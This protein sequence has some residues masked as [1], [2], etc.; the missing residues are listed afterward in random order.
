MIVPVYNK[1]EYVA[2]TIES[3]C[4][5]S[6]RNLE[7]ILVND[8]STD[9]SEVVCMQKA[10]HDQRIKYITQENAGPS[11]AR[12]HGLNV[13]TG[14]YITFLDADDILIESAVESMMGC[15]QKYQADIV[16]TRQKIFSNGSIQTTGDSCLQSGIVEK[17]AFFKSLAAD[18][19]GVFWGSQGNKLYARKMISAYDLHF[20]IDRRHA[21]DFLFNLSCF[22]LFPRIAF[23]NEVTSEIYDVPA[24]LSK[25][26]NIESLTMWGGDVWKALTDFYKENGQERLL[27]YVDS[28]FCR[29]VRGAIT[30]QNRNRSPSIKNTYQIVVN[31]AKTPWIAECIKNAC[32]DNYRQRIIIRCFQVKAYWILALMYYVTKG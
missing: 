1:K 22:K 6:Y 28:I 14:D 30:E 26:V 16:V 17:E 24:S 15:I 12:N 13:A 21:E 19:I 10:A 2:R 18:N 27:P 23:L 32:S 9:G 4:K 29:I 5:Q 25:Q 31:C 8:G 20:E 3:I 11:A 7:I